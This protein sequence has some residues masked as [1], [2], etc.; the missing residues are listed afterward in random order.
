[1]HARRPEAAVR[2]EEASGKRDPSLITAA[3]GWRHM[4]RRDDILELLQ[5]EHQPVPGYVLAERF[6]VSRQVVVHDI[7]LLRASGAAV[8]ATPRGYILLRPP[9]GL[10]TTV[11]A[12]RHRPAD[13]AAELYGLVDAGVSVVDVLVEHPIYGEMRGALNLHS[14][15]DVQ[16]FLDRMTLQHGQLLSLLTDGVHWHTVRARDEAT[17]ERGRAALRALGFLADGSPS[18]SK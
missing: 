15:A 12:V 16:D 14:R 2:E 9:Q 18:T 6:A 8:E 11:Y 10:Y 3:R 5:Q 7:A 13:T 17:L 1:M 4:S